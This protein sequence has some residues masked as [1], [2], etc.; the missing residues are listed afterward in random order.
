M[1]HATDRLL[2][3][4]TLNTCFDGAQQAAQWLRENGYPKAHDKT[5]IWAVT[6]RQ[7]TA[8]GHIWRWADYKGNRVPVYNQLPKRHDAPTYLP[9][10]KEV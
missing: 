7:K 5:I 9:L 1:P 8:Y 10:F 6:G 2:Y 4:V 3:C